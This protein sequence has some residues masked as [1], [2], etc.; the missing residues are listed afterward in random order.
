AVPLIN[1]AAKVIQESGSGFAIPV[2]DD[3][4]FVQAVEKLLN[5]DALRNEMG[6]KARVY[7]ET[8]F[9]IDKIAERFEQIL[10]AA[11]H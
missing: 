2:G 5:D 6:R 10:A 11:C 4:G 1:R 7:A 8:E 9:D 3:Q